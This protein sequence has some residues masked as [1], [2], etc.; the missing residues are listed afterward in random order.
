ML[1]FIQKML[2]SGT[3]VSSKRVC[4]FIGWLI[5]LIILIY[6]TFTQTIVPDFAS[7]V[8]ITSATLLGVE[9]VANAFKNNEQRED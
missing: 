1:N 5:C 8:L 7:T 9:T 3:G 6:A 4:G 2:T